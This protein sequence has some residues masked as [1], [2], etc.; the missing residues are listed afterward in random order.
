MPKYLLQVSY[1]AEGAKGV[2]KDGGSKRRA[3][4]KALVEGLGGKLE[5]LYF[6][7]G[8][9]DVFAIVDMPDAATAAAAS[10]TIAASGAVTSKTIVLLTPEEIDSATK[11]SASYTPPGR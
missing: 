10:M 7:F 1:T 8:D 4:A 5:T 6:A 11:K 2:L 3:A 9:C